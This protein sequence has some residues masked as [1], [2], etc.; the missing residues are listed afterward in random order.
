MD[1]LS[2]QRLGTVTEADILKIREFSRANIL[3][4]G[5]ITDLGDEIDISADITNLSTSDL[6]PT[7]F[8]IM[9][10]K[11]NMAL[12]GAITTVEQEKEQELTELI[13]ALKE[14][15]DQHKIELENV[16]KHGA[17]EIAER[18]K[19]AKQQKRAELDAMYQSRIEQIE[20]DIRREEENKRLKVAA[21]EQQYQTT[22]EQIEAYIR[23][24]EESKRQELVQIEQELR[25]QSTLFAKLKETEK[26]VMWYETAIRKIQD[27][28]DRLNNRVANYIVTGM[29]IKDVSEVLGL[30]TNLNIYSDSN[31]PWWSV[32]DSAYISLHG[33]YVIVW[34]E[35]GNRN[36]VTIGYCNR[37]TF[38]CY[39]RSAGTPGIEEKAGN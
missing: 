39:T 27:R 15:I 14:E 4:S 35:A 6:I 30:T 19:A 3:I 22:V 33:E 18:L 25:N 20:A 34:S 9:K 11:R 26:M 28:I 5:T 37:R 13:Q 31:G 16:V 32:F 23:R 1:E 38:T 10:T 24:E 7:S 17:D 2:F 29:T 8:R 12:I 21:L 36:P